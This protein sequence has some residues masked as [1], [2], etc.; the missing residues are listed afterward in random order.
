[1][2]GSPAI[3]AGTS[4]GAPTTDQRGIPRPYGKAV[5]IGA[6][7]SEYNAFRFAS[8][9]RVNSTDLRLRIEGPPGRVCRIQVSSNLLDW[10]NMYLSGIALTGTGKWEF[11]DQNAATHPSRFYRALIGN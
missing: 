10:E 8:I 11:V 2:K 4:A 3:D 6:Y 7:E 1:M 5:D 9:T